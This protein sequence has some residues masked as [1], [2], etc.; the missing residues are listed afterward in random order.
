M[1]WY[2]RDLLQCLGNNWYWRLYSTP[3]REEETDTEA[4]LFILSKQLVLAAIELTEE[5]FK[6]IVNVDSAFKK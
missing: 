6:T 3:L 5:L 2:I 4:S 1:K